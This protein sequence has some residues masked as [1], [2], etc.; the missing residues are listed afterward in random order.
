MS[1][2]PILFLIYNRPE[3]TREVFNAITQYR[4]LE[5][6][7]ASDGPNENRVDDE[8]RVHDTIRIT[9]DI[10]W[11]CRV[12]RLQ[13]NKHLGCKKAVSGAI[14][15][16]FRNVDQGIILEDDIF[17]DKSFF[18][19]AQT[20]LSKYR[21]DS[22]IMHIGGNNFQPR[23]NK[24]SRGYYFSKYAHVWGWASWRRA[25]KYYS[26][27]LDGWEKKENK[28]RIAEYSTGFWEKHYWGTMFNA[29]HQG[30]IDTWDYQWLY[31]IWKK[32]GISICPGVNLVKN[33]GF[34]KN[35]THTKKINNL[36]NINS[37]YLHFPLSSPSTFVL[38][39][40]YDEYTTKN[41]FKVSPKTVLYLKTK[42]GL[43]E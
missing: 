27:D 39:N 16:F 23:K 37:Q 5:L 43:K 34:G 13:R 29:V 8:K 12:K 35:A 9:S 22:K 1:K 11:K 17:P 19:F 10:K 14:D 31:S 42:Y 41:I 15:W 32:G 21:D 18:N 33:I 40:I 6:F 38:K 3:T 25:W 20:M 2:V 36:I 30:K 7:I 24:I 28:K 4:P 26:V